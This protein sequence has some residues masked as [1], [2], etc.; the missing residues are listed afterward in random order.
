M[1]GADIGLAGKD[2]A[3]FA[4]GPWADGET[5]ENDDVELAEP[6]E[7]RFDGGPWFEDREPKGPLDWG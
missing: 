5:R 4:L 7:K 6:V 3:A 1:R 2:D